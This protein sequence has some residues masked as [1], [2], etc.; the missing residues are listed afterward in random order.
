M[1]IIATYNPATREARA[2]VYDIRPE[3]DSPEMTLDRAGTMMRRWEFTLAVARLGTVE[4][5]WYG[6]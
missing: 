2:T 1:T 6:E 4:R 5:R 3:L